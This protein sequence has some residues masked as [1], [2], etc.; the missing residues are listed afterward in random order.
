M[1]EH[2]HGEMDTKPHEKTFEGFIKATTWVVGL[3]IFVLIFLAL[4]NS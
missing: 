3:S 1:A 4:F 2:K